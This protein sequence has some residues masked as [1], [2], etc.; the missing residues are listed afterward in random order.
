M[1][2]EQFDF[3]PVLSAGRHKSARRGAC[4]MEYASY[5]AGMRW[6]DHPACTHPTLAALARLVNDLTSDGARS[7][8]AVHIPSVVGLAGDDPRVPLLISTIAAS[9]ALPIA[10]QT[11]QRALA[12]ALVRCQ[13][14]LNKWDGPEIERA[15]MRIRVAFLLTPGTEGW[16]RDYVRES[17]LHLS[18]AAELNDEAI[19]R[20]AVIGI[21]DACVEDADARLANLL[22]QA[23]EECAFVFDRAEQPTGLPAAAVGSAV[24]KLRV[25]VST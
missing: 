9:A 17:A 16:A 8:L 12:T 1:S 24:P 4:F 20:T 7:Q 23:I 10:S 13:Q 2:T 25:P 11:R 3:L 18:H 5:L 6:S 19:L 15:R 22:A 14:L 21:A